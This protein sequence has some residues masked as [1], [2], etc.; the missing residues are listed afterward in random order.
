MG[1]VE[2]GAEAS[3]LCALAL[4]KEA[5]GQRSANNRHLLLSD[6]TMILHLPWLSN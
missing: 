6:S 2:R 5:Q 4:W 1:F 3:W